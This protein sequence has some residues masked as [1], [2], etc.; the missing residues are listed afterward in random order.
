MTP[1]SSSAFLPGV[2]FKVTV[3][4][5]FCPHPTLTSLR[6]HLGLWEAGNCAKKHSCLPATW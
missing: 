6:S 2:V 4:P 1:E 5:D 3:V